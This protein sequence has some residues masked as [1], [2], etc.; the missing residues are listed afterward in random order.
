[1]QKYIN[2]ASVPLSMAVFLATDSYDHESDT[3]SATALLKPV[4][5]LI[6]SE[7]VPEEMSMVDIVG[8]VKSRMG[9]AIHDSIE[10]AWV[11]NHV[12]AMTALGY[13]ERLTKRVLVNP[14]PEDVTED[15]IPVY[16]EQR[17]YKDI[18]GFRVSGKY[19]F[20]GE[21]RVEDFKTTG[22][23]TWTNDSKTQDY[24]LQGSIYRWLNPEIITQ[25]TMAIQFLFTD[26]NQ[27]RAKSDPKYPSAPIMQKLIPLL[28]IEET[29]AFIKSKLS[30]FVK[31]KDAP[32]DTLPLC[33]DK[34]LWRSLPSFKY[35][36]NPEKTNRSTKNY[37]NKQEAYTRLATDGNVGLV[38]EVPGQVMACK[39]CAAF[40]ICTQKDALIADGSLI[41]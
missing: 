18:M 38:K 24:K 12:T 15:V 2:G 22:T 23:F 30:Q 21:G 35:Y 11:N 37:D 32:E 40:P 8:L 34:E 19:D 4:R 25:D 6:L 9:T 39:Y 31:Y 33:T 5:Q 16:L 29:E 7:R 13:P 41:I 17:S 20:V 28:S 27:G 36:K 3:I 26:W 1:M 10:S 14:K